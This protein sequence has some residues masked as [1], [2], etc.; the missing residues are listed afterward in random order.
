MDPRPITSRIIIERMKLKPGIKPPT[1]E[2]VKAH[3]Q[4]F[5]TI[6]AIRGGDKRKNVGFVEFSNALE[7]EKALAQPIHKISDCDIR[8]Y[9]P[10]GGNQQK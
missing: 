2:A 4:Q 5:G 1:H 6:L 3:F 9:T 7:A 10:C 8:V